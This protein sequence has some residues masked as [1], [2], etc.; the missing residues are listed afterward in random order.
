M[1]WIY[2]THFTIYRNIALYN[3][4]NKRLT[5]EKKFKH[6]NEKILNNKA[7][8]D[9]L[10]NRRFTLSE[11]EPEKVQVFPSA[12]VYGDCASRLDTVQIYQ[13]PNLS[14]KRTRF[15]DQIICM[16]IKYE[17]ARFT[18]VKFEFL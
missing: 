12:N 4:L 7:I 18:T 3:K 16:G 9:H 15:C 6:Y 2:Y 1:V 13:K 11:G 10:F 8:Q 17:V 14:C 5:Y